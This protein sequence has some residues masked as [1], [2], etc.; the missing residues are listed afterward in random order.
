MKAI[1]EI[2]ATS[3]IS[4]GK[5]E[6]IK[7]VVG[8]M[9]KS[10]IGFLPVIDE[11]KKVIG[12]ITDRDV[13]LAISKASKPMNELKVMDVMNKKA[14]LI[15]QD[16]D[17]HAALKMMRTHQVGRLP[18]VDNENHLKGIVSLTRIVRKAKESSEKAEIEYSG[19]ENVINTLS[20][21]AERNKKKQNIEE[22]AEE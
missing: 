8:H 14:H 7:T 16:E 21:I 12:T 20:A 13:C 9:S 22:A 1:K 5:N 4:C 15:K 11:N 19:K 17:V 3:P 2:M 18:V 6:T 10:N